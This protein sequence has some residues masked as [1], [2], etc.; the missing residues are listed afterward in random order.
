MIGNDQP[1]Y[2]SI[3]R[4][5]TAGMATG[6]RF[7]VTQFKA[8]DSQSVVSITNNGIAPIYYDA[9]VTVNGMRASKSLK[10]LMP[11]NSDNYTVASGGM[12]PVLTIES[13]RLV[14]GQ[15]ITYEANISSSD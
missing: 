10:D 5:K 6:Y 3:E 4:I 7:Q 11:G 1:R 9:Y 12:S 8:S 2:Q 13:D 14:E 15:Q